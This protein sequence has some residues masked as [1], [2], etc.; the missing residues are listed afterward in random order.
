[1]RLKRKESGRNLGAGVQHGDNL[2][3]SGEDERGS[4]DVVVGVR[5]NIGQLDELGLQLG[6]FGP[7]LVQRFIPSLF[8]IRT[9]LQQLRRVGRR[10]QDLLLH[11]LQFDGK[12]NFWRKKVT[13]NKTRV[14]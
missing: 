11:P 1:M 2:I 3:G 12:T 5:H 8:Q 6:H 14:I 4:D 13:K 10:L 7:E 9:S